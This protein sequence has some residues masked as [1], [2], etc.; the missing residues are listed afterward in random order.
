MKN[1]FPPR[2]FSLFSSASAFYIALVNAFPLAFFLFSFLI[3]FGIFLLLLLLSPSY[4]FLNLIPI[5]IIFI[6]FKYYKDNQRQWNNIPMQPMKYSNRTTLDLLDCSI[7]PIAS[8]AFMYLLPINQKNNK[9]NVS[10]HFSGQ[11]NCP[12]QVSRYMYFTYVSYIHVIPCNLLTLNG[13]WFFFL[14][15][16][17]VVTTYHFLIWWCLLMQITSIINVL[18]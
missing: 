14:P 11:I 16:S 12:A 9:Y 8:S 15:I 4:Y 5:L 3:F 1:T 7:Y 10:L 17:L 6:Y 2:V 13:K 18:R